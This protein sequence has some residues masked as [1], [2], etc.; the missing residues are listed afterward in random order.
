MLK[1][2]NV[3]Y[4]KSARKADDF[5]SLAYPEFAFLGRSNVGKSSF[6]NMLMGKKDL[7]KVGSTPGVTKTIN[8]FI[9]ND[10][11]SLVD[12]PGYGYAKLPMELRKSF[13]P[14]IKTYIT[15]RENLRLAFLLI[16]IRRIPGDFERDI[17]QELGRMNIPV[18]VVATKCDKLSNNSRPRGIREI[19]EALQIDKD[20]ILPSS[21]KNSEGRKET[22]HL[23]ESFS[24]RK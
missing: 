17:I 13:L 7:V 23:I 16:D 22:L 19:A 2:K 4:L 9:L 14:L 6:I 11:I 1:I 24:A 18:A 21:A 10:S 20:Q 5:P 8:F 3:Y 12:L 15:G